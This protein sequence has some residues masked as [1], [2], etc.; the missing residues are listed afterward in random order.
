MNDS[1]TI[2]RL[3]KEA[4]HREIHTVRG[5]S[6]E[7]AEWAKLIYR[8]LC[9]LLGPRWVGGMTVKGHDGSFWGDENV[10]YND[11]ASYTGV[12]TTVEA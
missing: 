8:D 11:C 1:Y 4:S 3:A 2:S 12:S 5:H 7:V 10:L 9:D 6:Q